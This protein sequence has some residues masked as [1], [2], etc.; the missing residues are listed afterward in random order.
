MKHT[1]FVSFQIRFRFQEDIMG[2]NVLLPKIKRMSS[3]T[4]IAGNFRIILSCVF[5]V[6][7]WSMKIL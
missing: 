1:K 6:K 7:F 2:P 4:K 3:I 5:P